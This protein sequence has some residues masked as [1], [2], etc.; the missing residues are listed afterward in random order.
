MEFLVVGI[1][2]FC[3]AIARYLVYLAERSIGVHLFPIGTLFINLFGCL[4]AGLLL[5]QI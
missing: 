5:A 2:G 4:L 3:G 1:G